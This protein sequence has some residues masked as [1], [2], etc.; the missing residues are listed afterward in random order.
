MREKGKQ[1]KPTR[2][3]FLCVFYVVVVR[4]WCFCFEIRLRFGLFLFLGVV[5]VSALV[6]VVLVPASVVSQEVHYF[7]LAPCKLETRIRS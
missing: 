5:R 7:F 2:Q 4:F 1:S 6:L 3:L